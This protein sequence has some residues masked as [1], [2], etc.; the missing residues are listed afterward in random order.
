MKYCDK[1]GTS[2]KDGDFYCPECGAVHNTKE[3]DS[4]HI[5]DTDNSD[6]AENAIENIEKRVA[7]YY[8]NTYLSAGKSGKYVVLHHETTVSGDVCNVIVRYQDNKDSDNSSVSIS[9]ADVSVNMITGDCTVRSKPMKKTVKRTGAH[10]FICIIAILVML[11]IVCLPFLCNRFWDI[12]DQHRDR[13]A[14]SFS[15][16]IEDLGDG[17]SADVSV[18]IDVLYYLGGFACA[19][20]I[21]INALRKRTGACTFGSTVGIGLILYL[22]WQIY[23][24]TT[25]WYIG[26]NNAH[27]TFGFYIT[28][29]GFIAVL[30]A[31]SCDGNK[32]SD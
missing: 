28:C 4:L 26:F 21:F 24:G 23:S 30:I 20:F 17:Y 29:A 14:R 18:P 22:L 15:D 2:L 32:Y 1:C 3:S 9:V 13:N 19:L 8:N 16:L 12:R 31:S 5:L 27:L 11:N 10:M 7:K 25:T 6:P